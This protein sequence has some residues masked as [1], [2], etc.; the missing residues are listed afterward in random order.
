MDSLIEEMNLD[1]QIRSKSYKEESKVLSLTFRSGKPD[2]KHEKGVAGIPHSKH[3]SKVECETHYY[4][5]H[6]LKNDLSYITM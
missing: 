3:V 2:C 6:Y 4:S 5:D 1:S